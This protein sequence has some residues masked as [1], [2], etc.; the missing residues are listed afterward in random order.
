M[1]SNDVAASTAQLVAAAR[2]KAKF[3][4]PTQDRL[5]EASKAV[6]RACKKLVEKVISS[7]NKDDEEDVDYTSLSNR[8]FKKQ[9]LAQKVREYPLPSPFSFTTIVPKSL[10]CS[11]GDMHADLL[12]ISFI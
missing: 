8:E 10:P 2:V 3:G 7:K 9:E 5:E 12:I 11:T 4:S 6:K 1:A